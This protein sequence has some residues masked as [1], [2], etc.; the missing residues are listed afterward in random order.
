[1]R[2]LDCRHR[3]TAPKTFAEVA[4]AALFRETRQHEVAQTAQTGERFR[5]RA[6]RHP[7]PAYFR[8]RPR[9]QSGLGVVA[10]AQPVAH[11]GSDGDD[12][13]Q[14]AAV[15]HAED[16]RAAVNAKLGTVE[17]SLHRL[18]RA[19][20]FAGANHRGRNAQRHF[21][22]KAR[23]GK[24]GHAIRRGLLAQY[25]AHR[26][27]G[28]KFNALGHAHHDG[29]MPFQFYGDLTEGLRRDGH[30]QALGTRHRLGKIH[31]HFPVGRQ[32]HA[33]QVTLIPPVTEFVERPDVNVPKCHGIAVFV[34]HL[35]QGGSPRTR[36]EHG[37]FHFVASWVADF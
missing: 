14:R 15:F 35:G 1:M 13:F 33:G 32:R 34:E 17:K 26:F 24:H 30:G 3:F 16:V 4:I 9:D 2:R 29:R 21:A 7:Q 20:A 25:P 22:G 5:L 36:A 23:P 18:R 11:A 8:Q 27:A 19:V 12:V 37:N 10:V 28:L 6:A 31:L